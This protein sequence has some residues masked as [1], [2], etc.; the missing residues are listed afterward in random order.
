M[1]MVNEVI[2][3]VVKTASE[4]MVAAA[5]DLYEGLIPHFGGL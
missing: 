4:M 1:E 2:L 5:G 3:K